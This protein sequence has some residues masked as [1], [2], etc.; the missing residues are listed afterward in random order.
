MSVAEA[1]ILC[2]AD[3]RVSRSCCPNDT[4]AALDEGPSY[5][6]WMRDCSLLGRNQG[7]SSSQPPEKRA[8]RLRCIYETKRL[9]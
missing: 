4:V 5:E 9:S 1:C 6:F 2:Q 3:I 8:S 7:T